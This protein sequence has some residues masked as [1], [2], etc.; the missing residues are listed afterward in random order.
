MEVEDK[1]D[2][3]DAPLSADVLLV[4]TQLSKVYSSI[5][6]RKKEEKEEKVQSLT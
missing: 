1:A 3:E 6:E 2:K 4:S 5:H